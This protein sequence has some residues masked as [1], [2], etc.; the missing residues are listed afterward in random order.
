M[1]TATVSHDMRTP[2]NAMMGLLAN[3]D[4]FVLEGIGKRFLQ[5]IINSSKFMSYLVNDLL[6]LYQLKNGKF[7]KNLNYTDMNNSIT[8]LLEMFQLGA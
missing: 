7:R 1:L 6:D 4:P 8:E 3:L 2:L 5:I